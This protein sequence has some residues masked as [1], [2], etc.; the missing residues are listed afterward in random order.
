MFYDPKKS[1]CLQIIRN[2]TICTGTCSFRRTLVIRTLLTRSSTTT[3]T[4]SVTST[5]ATTM[6]LYFTET[7]SSA[8]C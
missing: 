7:L 6:I 2:I 5:P 3:T 8:Q 4:V 1:V